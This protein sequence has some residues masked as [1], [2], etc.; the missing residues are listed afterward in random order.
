MVAARL[1]SI[2]FL[3]WWLYQNYFLL[4]YVSFTA[5]IYNKIY[6][7]GADPDNC[8][9]FDDKGV[10]W[11]VKRGKSIAIPCTSGLIGN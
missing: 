8:D 10:R 9:G 2:E 4:I 5:I 11:T 1:V 7:K 3:L 6:F